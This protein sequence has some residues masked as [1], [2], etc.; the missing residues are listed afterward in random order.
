MLISTLAF[1]LVLVLLCMDLFV[2]SRSILS[3]VTVH[4]YYKYVYVFPLVCPDYWSHLYASYNLFW[5]AL[6]EQSSDRVETVG[7]IVPVD[8]SERYLARDIYSRYSTSTA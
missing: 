8:V 3:H 5:F 2:E 6:R 1:V 7:Y 4:P